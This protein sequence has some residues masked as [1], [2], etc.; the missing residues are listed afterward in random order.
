MSD[1]I[2]AQAAKPE[3]QQ[4]QN[5]GF[6]ITDDNM[7]EWAVQKIKEA[8]S[9]TEKWKAHFDA[10]FEAIQ[11]SN[12]GTINAMKSFLGHYFTKVPHRKTK[13]QEK[14]ELPSATLIRKKQNPEYK[15]DN[16]ALLAYLDNNHRTDLICIKREPAWDAIKK[17]AVVQ[18]ETLVDADTGEVIS[19]VRVIARPDVFDVKLKEK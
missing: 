8:Q 17:T 6:Q 2:F 5:A 15:S 14:Y 1:A 9:D 18:G 13:T 19:G 16:E 4:D 7:A 11:K 3:E 10:Q 12:E